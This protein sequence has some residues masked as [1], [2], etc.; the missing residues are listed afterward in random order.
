VAQINSG[1]SA[2]V[3]ALINCSVAT[4]AGAVR[5]ADER[6]K[7]HVIISGAGMLGIMACAMLKSK[8]TAHI[9]VIDTDPSRASRALDFGA[10]RFFLSAQEAIDQ[11]SAA[12]SAVP[13]ASA[14]L[15]FSGSAS[16][17]SSSLAL[18]KIGGKAVWVGATF[19]QKAV[20]VDAEWVI[21][22]LITIKGLHNYNLEDFLSAIEF[23][24]AH[25][26]TYNFE[27]LV[28]E[29]DGIHQ[30]N[31]AFKYAL[32]SAAYRVGIRL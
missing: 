26:L 28:H 29:F 4:V 21:R 13:K 32:N 14:I 12:Q 15:E 23:I 31:K 9:S 27:N 3:A 30:V 22:N 25:H 17:M 20:L 2:K 6:S 19:P 11:L 8:G 1:V 7:E 10:D 18:L 5:L 16:A 24:E